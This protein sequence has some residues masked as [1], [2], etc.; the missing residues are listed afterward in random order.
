MRRRATPPGIWSRTIGAAVCGF[1]VVAV[2]SAATLA[3][4]ATGWTRSPD[5]GFAGASIH[6]ASSSTTLCRW[7]APATAAAK[8]ASGGREPTGQ[9]ASVDPSTTSTSTAV[10]VSAV[11][12]SRVELR[13]E[14][15]GIAVPLTSITVT[16]GGAWAGDFTVPPASQVP[17][18][19]YQ[20]IAHCV[21]DDPSLDGTRS[22]DFDPQSFGVVEGPPPTAVTSAPTLPP[23]TSVTNPVQVQGIRVTRDTNTTANGGASVPTLPRTGD[24]TLTVGLAGAGALIA[25]GVALWWGSRAARRTRPLDPS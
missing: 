6:V 12:G 11:D 17:A 10:R 22:F 18:A 2:I 19:G 5:A 7:E 16:T 8:A 4:A 23:P 14:R 9:V 24:G 20:L 21:V 25:G 15:Q 13:L 3:G 1:G